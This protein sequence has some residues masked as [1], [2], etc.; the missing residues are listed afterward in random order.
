MT[1]T[2]RQPARL[3]MLRVVAREQQAAERKVDAIIERRN[4]L[5]QDD[6]DA[7]D[8]STPKQLAAAT[9][10]TENTIRVTLKRLRDRVGIS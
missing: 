3:R 8:R 1:A 9:G 4:R 7:P 10:L 6:Q 5:L 2:Y